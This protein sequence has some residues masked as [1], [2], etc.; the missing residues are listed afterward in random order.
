MLLEQ[1]PPADGAV[2]PCFV[3]LVLALEAV[4]REVG[5]ELVR[6]LEVLEGVLLQ[7]Q[8]EVASAE[9]HHLGDCVDQHVASDV[10]FV[11]VQQQG[12]NVV[13]DEA[14]LLQVRVFVLGDGLRR[15]VGLV[16]KHVV[17]AV[18]PQV[19]LLR[20]KEL[21]FECGNIANQANASTLVHISG[22]VDPSALCGVVE[23]FYFVVHDI[24][25]VSLREEQVQIHIDVAFVK[26]LCGMLP[27][28][29]QEVGLRSEYAHVGNVVDQLLALFEGEVV[30]LA[31]CLNPLQVEMARELLLFRQD[32]VLLK[33]GEVVPDQ[34]QMTALADKYV[35]NSLDLLLNDLNIVQ[36]GIR[37]H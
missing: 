36:S 2:P 19:E 20:F 26:Y 24:Q 30:D 8:P 28:S 1:V 7:G 9:E 3:V 16:I 10:E 5:E 25:P 21:A 18:L 33:I 31:R 22:F 23:E 37:K 32:V 29:L 12:R 34:L 27:Q 17:Q 4:V 11:P 6:V 14:V 13:L 15:Q 35:L